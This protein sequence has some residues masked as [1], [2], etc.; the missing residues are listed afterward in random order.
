MIDKSVNTSKISPQS[1]LIM[2]VSAECYKE[3]GLPYRVTSMTRNSGKSYH[4]PKYTDYGMST[5]VDSAIK[6]QYGKYCPHKAE[7]IADMIRDRL[8][9]H[10]DIFYGDDRHKDH[11]HI[12][13]D[14]KK[15]S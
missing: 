5:A 6:D 13:F 12:E 14:V 4:N 3:V 11:I 2:Q 15:A 7:I 10:Y 9:D 8:P 1:V